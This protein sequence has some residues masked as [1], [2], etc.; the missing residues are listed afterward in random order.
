MSEPQPQE[1]G[2]I[3]EHE[4]GTV[5]GNVDLLRLKFVGKQEGEVVDEGL[6]TDL[7][8]ISDLG[9]QIRG[10]GQR[11]HSISITYS[12]ASGQ[13]Q[14][15]GAGAQFGDYSRLRTDLIE[16]PDPSVPQH[17]QRTILLHR[18]G[19][20]PAPWQYDAALTDGEGEKTGPDTDTRRIM[21]E[22][23]IPEEPK[24]IGIHE[25]WGQSEYTPNAKG[26]IVMLRTI[27]K[28]NDTYGPQ[29]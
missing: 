23:I 20:M 24:L 15:I 18:S 17:F 25:V 4:E 28:F 16:K 12:T 26:D 5:I 11:E 10:N 29:K 3:K 9:V 2:H 22:R 14:L 21:P 19:D 1:E 6:Q 13:I 7:F 27:R 8:A